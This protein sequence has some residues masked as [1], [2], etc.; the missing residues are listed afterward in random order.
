MNAA[1]LVCLAALSSGCFIHAVSKTTSADLG[2]L[3]SSPRHGVVGRLTLN[4]RA[5]STT[6]LISV[7]RPRECTSNV[8]SVTETRTG[9]TAKMD[10][11]D[12]GGGGGGGVG[13]A[14]AVLLAFAGAAAVTGVISGTI[15]IIELAAATERVER[16]AKFTGV[17][18]Y[19][20]PVLAA[21]LPVEVLFASGTLVT[22]TTDRQGHVRIDVPDGEP[23]EGQATVRA[24]DAHF[25]VSYARSAEPNLPRAPALRSPVDQSQND[26]SQATRCSVARVAMFEHINSDPDR[27]RRA[28]LL[29]AA[30]SCSATTTEDTAWALTKTA[31]IA[32]SE[33]NCGKARDVGRQVA[34]LDANHYRSV[35]LKHVEIANCVGR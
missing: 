8:Y 35:F 15:T 18:R 5:E 32:A 34:A 25:Q 3:Q 30:P 13:P 7:A 22:S 10:G 26:G 24:A 17:R 21:D 12:L 2:T 14:A 20:C 6:L 4:A 27:R 33:G 16:F 29:R 31:A 11:V 9:K 28:V 19:A 23:A 1:S